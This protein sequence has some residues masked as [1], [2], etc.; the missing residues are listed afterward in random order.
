MEKTQ[1][2]EIVATVPP[3]TDLPS[4]SVQG[5]FR[6][7]ATDA[8][9][10]AQKAVGIYRKLVAFIRENQLPPAYVKVELTQRKYSPPRIAEILKASEASTEDFKAFMAGTIGFKA[11]LEK[12]REAATQRQSEIPGTRMREREKL[13]QEL[14]QLLGE[15][16]PVAGKPSKLEKLT[17][18][19]VANGYPCSLKI[20]R[21][22]NR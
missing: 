8:I 2:L 19:V 4:S 16:L 1:Q 13:R 17:L 14:I 22:N 15:Y 9:N 6:K 18:L 5:E 3:G 7:L 10:A 21:R 20:G 12:T 11:V